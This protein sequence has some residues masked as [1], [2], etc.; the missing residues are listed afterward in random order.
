M[1]G[2][3]DELILYVESMR[4]Q[5]EFYRDV[6]G[7]S[8]IE[9]A[10]V[11]EPA[12]VTDWD[13]LHW[14]ALDAGNFRLALHAGGRRRFGQDSPRFVFA[15][16]DLD[17]ARQSLT[18]AGVSLGAERVPAAGTRVVDAWDPEGNVFSIEHRS[19]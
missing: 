14:V 11:N 10:P 5:L 1:L 18:G 16:D 7:L 4:H 8:V 9:P 3:L 19:H 12:R 17:Q 6:L 15:V 2:R 13:Q